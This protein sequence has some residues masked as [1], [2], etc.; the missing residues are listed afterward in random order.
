MKAH[1]DK[2]QQVYGIIIEGGDII[3]TD[4]KTQEEAKRVPY[5]TFKEKFTLVEDK[6]IPT[7]E[8]EKLKARILSAKYVDWAKKQPKEPEPAKEEITLNSEKPAKKKKSS[9]TKKTEK[10]EKAQEPANT[11]V[12]TLKVICENVGVSTANARKIL[13]KN[14]VDKPTSGSWTWDDPKEV[15]KIIKLLK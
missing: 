2:T 12:T 6:E 10:A 14:K 11:P 15:E 8:E 1:E 3:L 5:S 9:K 13:R 4:L 7:L